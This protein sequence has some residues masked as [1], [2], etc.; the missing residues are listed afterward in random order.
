MEEKIARVMAG[1]FNFPPIGTKKESKPLPIVASAPTIQ[2]AKT[3]K[4]NDMPP[5]GPDDAKLSLSSAG[6]GNSTSA[7]S[8]A[9][10]PIPHDE[11]PKDFTL[12][13]LQPRSS[14]PSPSPSP[15]PSSS[16]EVEPEKVVPMPAKVVPRIVRPPAK[17]EYTPEPLQ[18]EGENDDDD[19]YQSEN[20][21]DSDRKSDTEKDSNGNSDN[22]N[23]ESFDIIRDVQRNDPVE[24]KVSA[25][26]ALQE[27][28]APPARV[29][30]PVTT[31][32]N[33]SP[34]SSSTTT[35]TAASSSGN[36]QQPTT[37]HAQSKQR[38]VSTGR[39][40]GETSPAN[41]PNCVSPIAGGL[42]TETTSLSFRNK[43]KDR[44]TSA[45]K[46]K[47]TDRRS[48]GGGAAPSVVTTPSSSS[49]GLFS[50]QPST[51]TPQ[52]RRIPPPNQS[53]APGSSSSTHHEFGEGKALT[54]AQLL[55][56]VEP[57][58]L[59]R[60]KQASAV[61]MSGS[62]GKRPP[63]AGL[64]ERAIRVAVRV[65][66]FNNGEIGAN[67]RRI[68]SCNDDKLVIVNPN[69][70][71]ADPDAIVAAAAAANC[72][73]WAQTFKFDH[74]L[75]SYDPG[76]PEDEYVDQEGVHRAI[77]SEIVETILNGVS[78]S[79]FA[80]GHTGT[81][82]TH[83]FFG[84][85]EP[86]P[87]RSASG[88]D[89]HH[90]DDFPVGDEE[91]DLARRGLRYTIS[92]N[93][94]LIPRLVRDVI[95]GLKRR[96]DSCID[97]K[98]TLSFMEIYN[99]KIK[100]LLRSDGDG[101]GAFH[102]G[103]E[104]MRVR[105]HPLLG[106]YVEGLTKSEIN[107]PAEALRLLHL[108]HANRTT[109]AT[110][111][112]SQ[113]SRSHA[114]VVLELSPSRLDLSPAALNITRPILP[115]NS[116]KGTGGGAGSSG[117]NSNTSI[118]A[119]NGG[120]AGGVAA[121]DPFEDGTNQ[122]FVR[123]QMIDLAGSEKDPASPRARPDDDDIDGGGP[124]AGGRP[125]GAYRKGKLDLSHSS[126]PHPRSDANGVE[127]T[128]M[129]MIRRSLSTLGYIIKALGKGSPF[130]TLPYRDSVLTWLLRDALN[131]RNSTTM[132][133]TL[134]PAHNCHEESLSTLKYAERLCML[135]P[136]AASVGDPTFGHGPNSSFLS[137]SGMVGL[138]ASGDFGQAGLGSGPF[139]LPDDFGGGH[140]GNGKGEGW[141]TG[142][143]AARQLLRNMVSDPQQRL[144]KLNSAILSGR[145]ESA[146]ARPQAAA[147][148]MQVKTWRAHAHAHAHAPLQ[149]AGATPSLFIFCHEMV[150]FQMFESSFL[151][152]KFYFRLDRLLWVTL[153]IR[154]KGSVR[155][156]GPFKA[157][158]W[159]CRSSWRRRGPTGT[160]YWWSCRV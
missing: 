2:N 4:Y 11:S 82:K 154:Q 150:S 128:E 19:D 108:G 79:C 130:K 45:D 148:S 67:A 74:C 58:S 9:I 145:D 36:Q 31:T 27:T 75:W 68:I 60:R 78:A 21:D 149:R 122:L 13:R 3:P 81:G 85:L 41:D 129:K 158:S 80:Y 111:R 94:G 142:S 116:S 109:A 37:G 72:K 110:E 143:K 43:P 42:A 114:V 120:G 61:P 18:S 20:N 89:P 7:T 101:D 137:T 52:H 63:G 48:S 97:T 55:Q 12:D 91:E 14:S 133:A 151:F 134:S 83:S 90:D 22:D 124:G 50:G 112:N 59:V 84:S 92:E 152:F 25:P 54:Q 40:R 146:P 107:S 135:S 93:S 77:G 156:T 53:F 102:F 66:P 64:Q 5:K 30:K 139:A 155:P 71:D 46:T 100:D 38:A 117:R 106:P 86:M 132:L 141:Q 15:P 10:S 123:L 8:G 98:L 39:T 140:K 127:K 95:V 35:P 136:R 160:A 51:F 113:S 153:L 56:I 47:T 6:G 33:V 73:E 28:K 147:Q 17:Q 131:G 115:M 69:A 121:R 16:S 126:V 119:G 76:D 157:Q 44:P 96:D 34:R 144:A 99:E 104:A 159:S 26:K 125:S 1:N 24:A 23:D 70:F 88:Y 29:T 57:W 49:S 62:G 65:R 32:T 105:E 138:N 87:I 103:G 118:T